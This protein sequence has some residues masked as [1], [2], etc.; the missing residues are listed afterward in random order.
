MH[1]DMSCV[2]A[3][4][5]ARELRATADR[6]ERRH[7]GNPELEYE[8]RWEFQEALAT[9]RTAACWYAQVADLG[10]GVFAWY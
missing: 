2:E 8:E 5:F 9:I 7:G 3:S 1:K 10:F 4:C 6:I